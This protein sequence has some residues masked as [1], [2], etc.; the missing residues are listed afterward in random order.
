M[1]G[2]ESQRLGR[3]LVT[4]GTGF[5]GSSLTKR[6]VDEGC[7]VRVF[8]N[9]IRGSLERL[10]GYLDKLEYIEGDVTVYE[11]VYEACK[12][13]DTVFHL[14]YINGTENFYQIPEKVLEVGVKGAINTLDAAMKQGL[15]NY[16]VTSSSEVYQEPDHIPTAEDERI[17]IPDIKNPRFS[18]S[19]GKIINELLAI[20]YTARS[21][22]RTVICRPHN[23]YGPDMGTGHVIPQFILRM[24]KLSDDFKIKKISFP[25]QGTGEESRAFCYIDDAVDGLL[26]A[27]VRGLD[28][29][30]Y[31]VGTEDEVTVVRLAKEISGLLGLDIEIKPGDSPPGGTPRRCPNVAKLRS[32]GYEPEISLEEGIG[33]TLDWYLNEPGVDFSEDFAGIAK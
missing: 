28:K 26:L 14:A 5:I 29:N 13:I 2:L 23:F 3:I 21:G 17:L 20:H 4:G 8:D 15:K 19:G 18:Y 10:V 27:A 12:E 33:K 1:Q 30:I 6:L 16:I 32:L 7:P 24:K 9:N 22:L 31:H 25:I 11:Q